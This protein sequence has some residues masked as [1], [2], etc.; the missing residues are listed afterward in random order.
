VI[1]VLVLA[2]FSMWLF[3]WRRGELLG[4]VGLNRRAALVVAFALWQVLVAV[5]TEAAGIGRHFTRAT[6]MSLWAVVTLVVVVAL[7]R[8]LAASIRTLA[9]RRGP[10][11]IRPAPAGAHRLDRLVGAVVVAAVLGVLAVIGWLYPPSNP[12]SLVYHLARVEHWIQ[13]RSVTTFPT[14]YLAQVELSPLHEYNLA[15]FH[16]LAG[17]DR[18]D[19]YIQLFATVVC[20]L[21]VSELAGRL[22]L[23]ARGQVFAAVLCASVPSVILEATS[24]QNDNFGAAVGVALVIVLSTEM[25]GGWYRRG[26]AVGCVGGIAL[27][28]KGTLIALLGPVALLLVVV[29]RPRQARRGGG[30]RALLGGL[31]AGCVALVAAVVVAGPFVARNY[32]MFGAPAGPVSASTISTDLTVR[33]AA[34]NIIRSTASEFAIGNGRSGP[35][36]AISGMVLDSLRT[37]YDTLGVDPADPRYVLGVQTDAFEKTDYSTAERAEG[38]GANPLQVLL[39]AVSLVV[40]GLAV[41]TGR[42]RLRLPLVLALGL[43]LGYVAF[44]ANARWSVFAVRYYVPLLVLWCPLF[45]LAL[46][47]FPRMV[48]RVCAAVLVVACLPQ[49][50]DNG[51]RSLLH[52]NFTFDYPLAQYFAAYFPEERR[53]TAAEFEELTR[54]IARS[55]C[56]EVGIANWVLVEYPIWAGLRHAGWRGT[57]NAVDVSNES[58]R[59]AK[60]DFR[61]CALIRQIPPGQVSTDRA[62]AAFQ[63]GNMALSLDVRGLRPGAVTAAGFVSAVPGLSVLPGAGWVLTREGPKSLVKD[64][65]LFLSASRSGTV[66][67][68]VRLPGADTG[69]VL[70]SPDA[71]SVISA[72]GQVVLR[73]PVEPGANTL[74]LT[75]R[76]PLRPLTVSQVEVR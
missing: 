67:V 62:R 18:L 12:D 1:S 4:F 46:S 45:A 29:V 61:P 10:V 22:G 15:H 25:T 31:S 32:Q 36:T 16:L 3:V 9:A 41:V 26:I 6:V 75:R 19:G 38:K 39:I 23:S 73:V 70:S 54:T 72:P 21:G 40:F 2:V 5:G 11:R 43:C 71:S 58:A 64:A 28:T 68:R 42:R 37:A 17:T 35:A 51:A 59:Y 33:A 56:R 50:V 60:A 30:R 7:R 44:T 24:T 8:D 74:R 53:S 49:L 47:S 65:V 63:F 48:A 66:E 27:L 20:V 52:P 69:A 14:H 34:A 55:G 76:G 13:D 57:M